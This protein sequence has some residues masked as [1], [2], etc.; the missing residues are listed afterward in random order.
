MFDD[1]VDKTD[2]QKLLALEKIIEE[3]LRTFTDVGSA[4][5]QIRDGELYQPQYSSFEEYCRERWDMEHSHAYRLMDS[6]KVM[7]NLKTSPIGEVLPTN[8]SQTRPLASLSPEQQVEAWKEAT[9]TAPKGKRPTGGLVQKIVDRFRGK[10][11]N[12]KVRESG[13]TADEVKKDQPLFDALTA[14]AKVYGNDDTKDIRKGGA[15]LTRAE[16]LALAKLPAEKMRSIQDLILANHW[17]PK[18]ALH[19]LAQ[20][21]DSRSTNEE[22]QNWCLGTKNKVFS[23]I[24]GGFTHTCKANSK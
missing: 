16:V 4:L 18:K 13:W 9:T 12:K 6:A 8:E 21:P 23:V 15:G 17:P 7:A 20:K 3:G 10:P 24:I 1:L 2:N 14:I 19:F 5:L 22:M 11:S